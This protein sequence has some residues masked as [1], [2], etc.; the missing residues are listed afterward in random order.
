MI[1][2]TFFQFADYNKNNFPSRYQN[3]K[4]LTKKSVVLI[5]SQK[6]TQNIYHHFF[7][8]VGYYFFVKI[9]GSYKK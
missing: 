8:G 4:T 6:L 9:H 1:K 7:E 5:F 3:G 2:L